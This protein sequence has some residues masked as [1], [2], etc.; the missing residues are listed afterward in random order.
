MAQPMQ[1]SLL[2]LAVLEA[3]GERQPIGVAD[4]AR[5]LERPKSTAQ[6]ALV[7]L[8]QA[9]WVRPDGSDRTRWVLTGRVL[10]VAR[11]VANQGGLRDLARLPL[12][13]LQAATGESVTLCIREG[14]ET[15]TADFLEGTHSV[16]F[17]APVGVRTPLHAGAA[18]KVVLAYLG[19]ADQQAVLDGELIAVTEQTITSRTALAAELAD[20][21]ANGF[22]LS[23][24]EAADYA[25]GVAAPVLGSDGTA[26]ASIAVTAPLSRLTGEDRLVAVARLVVDTAARLTADLN[27]GAMPAGGTR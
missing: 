24:G 11:H 25:C 21:R 19:D 18:G 9:G 7:T 3:V 12:E 26:L 13:Q 6:R 20:I 10:S 2:T 4:L 23:R 16:R 27:R 14:D 1:S 8:Y 17:V 15:V 5:V 22:A